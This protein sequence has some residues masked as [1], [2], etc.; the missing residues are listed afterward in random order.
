M[1]IFGSLLSPE[2]LLAGLEPV[3][4][5]HDHCNS[6]YRYGFL[7]WVFLYLELSKN[8]PSNSRTGALF[9]CCFVDISWD[10][11]L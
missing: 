7:Y 8:Q 11:A 4:S 6:D 3:H 5:D 2:I 9:L 10:D 1:I